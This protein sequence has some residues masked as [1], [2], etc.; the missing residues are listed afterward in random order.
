MAKV[1]EFI[2]GGHLRLAAGLGPGRTIMTMD[3]PGVCRWLRA[4]SKTKNFPAKFHGWFSHFAQYSTQCDF[5][6]L[7]F[8][9]E[10]SFLVVQTKLPAVEPRTDRIMKLEQIAELLSCYMCV[11]LVVTYF[12]T[13][14][15]P[16]CDSHQVTPRYR[17][18][19]PRC[20]R[21]RW[22]WPISKPWT[23]TSTCPGNSEGKLLFLAPTNR[24]VPHFTADQVP[25][26]TINDCIYR[27]QTIPKWADES[28]IRSGSIAICRGNGSLIAG[29][30]G[31][32]KTA[33]FQKHPK[34]CLQYLLDLFQV[35]IPPAK[36]LFHEAFK[37]IFWLGHFYI[38]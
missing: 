33:C 8:A 7:F 16:Y 11:L 36:T 6:P 17:N 10:S 15:Y 2:S 25:Y 5:N 12:L 9:G 38:Y 28:D 32:S 26:S 31:I 29:H 20:Y 1:P 37:N 4:V 27:S 18:A 34:T 23:L 35:W 24:W 21:T 14:F 3:N 13:I 30:V 22:F 19:S